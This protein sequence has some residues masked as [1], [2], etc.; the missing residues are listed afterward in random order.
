MVE[1]VDV[2][3]WIVSE[4]GVDPFVVKLQFFFVKLAPGVIIVVNKVL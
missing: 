1:A 2:Q 3:S 4:R